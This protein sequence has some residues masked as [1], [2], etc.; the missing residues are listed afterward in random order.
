MKETEI[1]LPKI[2][3]KTCSLKEVAEIY[4]VGD[5]TMRRWLTPFKKDIGPRLGHYYSPKQMKIIFEK[6]GIPEITQ[7]K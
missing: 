5:R 4:Q 1:L 7:F 2:L 3:L 6:L